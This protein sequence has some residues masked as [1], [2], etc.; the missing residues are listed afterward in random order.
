MDKMLS[1]GDIVRDLNYSVVVMTYSDLQRFNSIER[2]FGRYDS[3]VL[4]YET[5]RNV[6]HWVCVFINDLGQIEHFDSYGLYPDDELKF[7]PEYFRVSN[8]DRIPHLTY[9]LYKSKR[10]V[11][12]NDYAL[13]LMA[14]GINTCGKWVVNRLL[15]KRI[16][17]DSYGKYYMKIKNRD[18]YINDHYLLLID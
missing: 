17:I 6:G 15:N 7:I 4:L 3:I 10:V 1:S 9:L 11:L 12:Y 5:S 8:Y 18:G 2:A 14:K 16:D 13:Q